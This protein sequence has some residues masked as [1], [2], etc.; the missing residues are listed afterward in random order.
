MTTADTALEVALRGNHSAH[1]ARA[2]ML[3]CLLLLFSCTKQDHDCPCNFVTGEGK[4]LN[5]L[6]GFTPCD[7]VIQSITVV[8]P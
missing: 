1:K 6:N 4:V 5:T 8:C 7:S 2:G 3:M